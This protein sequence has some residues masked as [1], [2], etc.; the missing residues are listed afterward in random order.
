MV[1]RE[2]P[3]ND[4]EVPRLQ[5]VGD[6]LCH[7]AD[8][9][10]VKVAV[11]VVVAPGTPGEPPLGVVVLQAGRCHVEKCTVAGVAIQLVGTMDSD[12]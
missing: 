1:E 9:D 10:Q 4:V 8:D 7:V 3:K 11:A 6:Q 5:H 2:A 12:E